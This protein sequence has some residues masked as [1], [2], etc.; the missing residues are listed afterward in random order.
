VIALVISI[1]LGPG[2]SVA[3]TPAATPPVATTEP[4]TPIAADTESATTTAVV[5]PAG[6][7]TTEVPPAGAKAAVAPA[8]AVVPATQGG[9]PAPGPVDAASVAAAP[10]APGAAVVAAPGAGPA[11]VAAPSA[12]PGP[13]QI[14][15]FD[16][17]FAKAAGDLFGK[18]DLSSVAGERVA[19][20]IDPLIDGNTRMQTRATQ[21]LGTRVATLVRSTYPRYDLQPFNGASLVRGALLFIGTLTAINT[22]AHPAEAEGARDTYRICL[23]LVNPRTG[24]IVGK[25]LAFAVGAGV[26][27]TPT[28]FFQDSP[29]WVPDPATQGY[30]GTCQGTKVGDPIKPAYWD[31]LLAAALVNDAIEAYE[32]GRYEEALDLYRGVSRSSAGDQIRVYNGI[33]LAAT[34]L[35]HRDEAAQAFGRLVD[36]GLQ[37]QRLGV[38]FLFRPGSTIF[39]TDAR[40]AAVYPGWLRTIAQQAARTDKCIEISG[41]TSRTGAEPLNERLSQLRADYVRQR[42]ESERPGLKQMLTAVGKGSRENLSGRGTDDFRDAVDRRVEFRVMSCGSGA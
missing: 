27:H 28:A 16:E 3:A 32:A 1:A 14:L 22:P 29:A 26:D 15:P 7:V 37:Q 13:P 40:E 11:P 34:R 31:R 9:A 19:Y 12:A 23:A 35:G 17:A 42:L 33:Y 20:T 2:P 21:A 30:V 25:G 41:H 8:T 5:P 6:A 38:K 4:S 18:A 36:Y 10:A 39:N 24:L